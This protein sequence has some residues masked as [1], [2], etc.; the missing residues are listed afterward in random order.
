MKGS[1]T[2][3][4]RPHLIPC[5]MRG[6]G[7]DGHAPGNGLADEDAVEGVLVVFRKAGELENGC[8][9][10]GERLDAVADA[11]V[12]DEVVAGSGSGSLPGLCLTMIPTRRQR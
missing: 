10:Q 2:L 1:H 12:L 4:L 9:I 3:P 7:E 6:R 8:F 5:D 11:V